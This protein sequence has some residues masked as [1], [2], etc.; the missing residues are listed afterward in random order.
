MKILQPQAFGEKSSTDTITINEFTKVEQ[1]CTP[2]LKAFAVCR[3]CDRTAVPYSKYVPKN[4]ENVSGVGMSY[5]HFQL[6]FDIMIYALA[7][8]PSS[9]SRHAVM[10]KNKSTI[11]T[12]QRILQ[13]LVRE[14]FLS[15]NQP[16]VTAGVYFKA[17]P[18]KLYSIAYAINSQ[19]HSKNIDANEF[20]PRYD[21]VP[22][23]ISHDTNKIYQ[24]ITFRFDVCLDILTYAAACGNNG[25][26]RKAVMQ[27]MQFLKER[28][29][30]RLLE[31]LV[32]AEF[33]IKSPPKHGGGCTYHF[34]QRKTD[35]L[36][37][38]LNKKPYSN[39][40]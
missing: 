35:L 6:R 7:C 25:F 18:S 39:Y 1:P 34:N 29:Q 5:K 10:Q 19:A 15:K 38:L 23:D 21:P 8:Y 3:I 20:L 12:Q 9:F 28:T 37:K 32:K 16:Y 11:R 17:V 4:Q 27:N 24:Q 2:F 31:N 22:T 14:G 33:L 30:Q 26:S 36:L 13:S 40:N